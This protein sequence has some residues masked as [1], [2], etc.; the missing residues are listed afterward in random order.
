[1]AALK[2]RA[3]QAS[4]LCT[5]PYDTAAPALPCS[6][7]RNSMCS[8]PR[9]GMREQRD[10][11]G[12]RDGRRRAHEGDAAG[13]H[14]RAAPLARGDAPHPAQLPLGLH[15]QLRRHPACRGRALPG[16]HNP[17]SAHARRRRHGALLGLGRVLLPATAPLPTAQ[18]AR[19][20][21]RQRTRDLHPGG[22]RA[23]ARGRV[24]IV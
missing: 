19:A 11:R 7:V 18:A 23:D 5:A 10:R 3:R 16:P 2:E 21:R 24:A 4:S 17:I 9:C 6:P 8:T 15:L 12:H 1:M 13:C 20:A 22:P 14:H